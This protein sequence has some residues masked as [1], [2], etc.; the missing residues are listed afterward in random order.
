MV[1]SAATF[2][3]V[4]LPPL[5][6]LYGDLLDRLRIVVSRLRP[7]VDVQVDFRAEDMGIVLLVSPGPAR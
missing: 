1:A 4:P 5:D 7:I 2:F 6:L 3:V